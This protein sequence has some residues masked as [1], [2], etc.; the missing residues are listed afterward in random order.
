MSQLTVKK[1]NVKTDSLVNVT[2]IDFDLL[3]LKYMIIT[4]I[5]K[6]ESYNNLDNLSEISK[7]LNKFL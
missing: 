1:Y 5:I 6:I 4:K 7:F 2:Q 3:E